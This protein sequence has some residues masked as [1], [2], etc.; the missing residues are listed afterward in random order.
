M[1]TRDSETTLTTA[2]T[3]HDIHMYARDPGEK[4]THGVETEEKH[5]LNIKRYKQIAN[6]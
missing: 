5:L 1:Y 2:I 4:K 3:L 6:D